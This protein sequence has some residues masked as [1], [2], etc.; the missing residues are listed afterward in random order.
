MDLA[1]GGNMRAFRQWKVIM[2]IAGIRNPE[3]IPAFGVLYS[4]SVISLSQ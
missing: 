1:I 3:S 2:T 4:G